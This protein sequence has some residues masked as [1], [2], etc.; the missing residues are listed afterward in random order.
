[1]CLKSRMHFSYQIHWYGGCYW[2][3]HVLF[4]LKLKFKCVVS[5][6]QRWRAMLSLA[7]L[8]YQ[9]AERELHG[10]E[11]TDCPV[12]MCRGSLAERMWVQGTWLR[13]RGSWNAVTGGKRISVAL[14]ACVRASNLTLHILV[15]P[16]L[17]S[18]CVLMSSCTF[19]LP[20]NWM[21]SFYIE[22]KN[23]KKPNRCKFKNQYLDAFN[24]ILIGFLIII[25]IFNLKVLAQF[26]TNPYVVLFCWQCF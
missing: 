4:Q 25:I 18:L 12:G 24:Y 8:K 14:R 3:S 7:G 13:I 11:V 20:F 16:V 19:S 1:M 6:L 10:M 21:L 17:S 5:D 15:L 22:Q 23:G 9:R 26:S 2:F